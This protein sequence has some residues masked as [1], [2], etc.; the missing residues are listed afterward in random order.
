MTEDKINDFDL[1][2]RREALAE[3]VRD[4]NFPPVGNFVNALHTLFILLI[5]KDILQADL[6]WKLDGKVWKWEE[7]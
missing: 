7:S 4:E 2:T 5:I 3:L 6:Y 1:S